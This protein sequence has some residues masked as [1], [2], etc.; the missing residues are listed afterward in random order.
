MGA[1]QNKKLQTRK[2]RIFEQYN[3]L[4]IHAGDEATKLVSY[5]RVL[6]RTLVSILFFGW[7]KIP[8][9]TKELL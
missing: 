9:K 5:L 2:R 4:G 1:R 6:A 8:A 7:H 3:V